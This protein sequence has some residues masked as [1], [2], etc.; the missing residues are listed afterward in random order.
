MITFHK[1]NMPHLK[2][3][4]F[5][6]RG[7]FVFLLSM[8]FPTVLSAADA[9]GPV[10]I[11]KV[12]VEGEIGRRIDVTCHNNLMVADLEN[13]FLAPFKAKDRNGGYI[14]LGK[15]I[16]AAVR[17]AAYTGDPKVLERKNYLVAETLRTQEPDGY[18]GMLKAEV[19]VS[20]LWDVHEMGYIVFGLVSDYRFFEEKK[21]LD[22]ASKLADYII[23]RWPSKQ[24]HKAGGGR[25][26]EHMAV[27]GLESAMLALHQASGEKKY[28]DFC[29]K[30]R[31]LPEWDAQIVT[32]RWGQ[33]E[34][35]AYAHMCRNIA[36]LRLYRKQADER[37]LQPAADVINFLTAKD[38]LVI[39]GGTSDNECWQ[40]TQEGIGNLGETCATAYLIR[41]LDELLR[42]QADSRYGDLMER[43]IYNA[44][45]AAQ[46]PDGRQLRYYAPFD[47]PR[48]YFNRDTY[49]C[50]CNY[51]RIVAELPQMVYYKASDSLAVNLYTP[52][53]AEITLR[54]GLRVKLRQKTD[55]PN[56][57]QVTIH[58]DPSK[59]ATFNLKLRIPRWCKNASVRLNDKKPTPALKSGEFH[60]IERSWKKGD[61]VTV[62]MPM[63]LRLVKGRKAQE[64]RVA[65][66]RGPLVFCLDP[67]Q[68]DKLKDVDLRLITL[69]PNSLEGPF[70]DDSVHPA[71]LKCRVRAWGAGRHP[72][73]TK[74]DLELTLT[75]FPDPDGKTVYL[76][77][78][79]PNARQFVDDEL[80][81]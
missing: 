7:S 41:L 38:G 16:D 73:T 53:N 49:C 35:H 80:L 25:I 21:S 24:D 9:L 14:G 46:S 67:S 5:P 12:R 71:G 42:M 18:I 19:R 52:S 81:E 1:G 27:T 36:Q 2:S 39:T 57:G 56:S 6:L 60:S 65:I 8:L 59:P 47:G 13:D 48:V 72:S 77:V 61:V 54:D 17:L 62:D 23:D 3:L 44:L 50:P 31:K 43:S 10:N 58:V 75:E 20:A 33:I 69:D 78:P 4:F 37:L 40:D 74:T 63:P 70:P 30:V 34:G 45:F 32:G 55:Y 64:G 66:M 15:T 22:A 68:N 28:L 51:R 76:K 26:T 29:V 79:N 11:R